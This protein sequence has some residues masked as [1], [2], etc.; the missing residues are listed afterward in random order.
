[1]VCVLVPLIFWS[2][3]A[4]VLIL[5]ETLKIVMSTFFGKMTMQQEPNGTSNGTLCDILMD[6][7]F[8]YFL[9]T[10]LLKIK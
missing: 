10:D 8:P 1:M 3:K 7:N 2:L 6:G 5:D 9:K 4:S